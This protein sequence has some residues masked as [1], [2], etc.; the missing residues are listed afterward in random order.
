MTEQPAGR[1]CNRRIPSSD[2]ELLEELASY[3]NP[4]GPAD[5]Y[6]SE[7]EARL[8]LLSESERRNGMQI[9]FDTETERWV[10]VGRP[11][12]RMCE[13]CLK[14]EVSG[15]RSDSKYCSDNCRKKASRKRSSSV[16]FS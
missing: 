13:V 8:W 15:G 9:F 6:L 14:R 7:A 1:D 5:K 10:P 16:T 2:E 3:A 11:A 4:C 12:P